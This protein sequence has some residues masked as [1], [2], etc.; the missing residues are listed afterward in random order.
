MRR[1]TFERVLYGVLLLLCVGGLATVLAL[2][3]AGVVPEGLTLWLMLAGIL[4]ALVIILYLEF[5]GGHG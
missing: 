5:R 3:A 1:R 2:T 4:T